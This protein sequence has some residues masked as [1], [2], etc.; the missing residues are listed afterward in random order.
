M[1]RR[2]HERIPTSADCILYIDAERELPGKLWDISEGGA[3]IILYE[4][5]TLE[6]GDTCILKFVDKLNTDT[7]CFKV[8]EP[9][10]ISNLLKLNDGYRVGV[11]FRN[12]VSTECLE[13][14]KVL[15]ARAILRR[16]QMM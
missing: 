12:K 5:S 1:E 11:A 3:C 10:T 6:I 8:M 9:V 7:A 16:Y 13:Y 2:L 15:S 14:V 4:E